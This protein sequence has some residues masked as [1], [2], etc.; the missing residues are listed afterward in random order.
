MS[1]LTI[2]VAQVRC[3][4][5]HYFINTGDRCGRVAGLRAC[6]WCVET[7]DD[8]ESIENEEVLNEQR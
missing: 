6:E 1:E 8:L 2:A 5:C 7:E 3:E 4:V